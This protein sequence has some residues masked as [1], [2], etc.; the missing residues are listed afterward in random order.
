MAQDELVPSYFLSKTC[1]LENYPYFCAPK[2]IIVSNDIQRNESLKTLFSWY[3]QVTMFLK[4]SLLSCNTLCTK[5]MG[6]V[7]CLQE[8]SFDPNRMFQCC[9]NSFGICNN[10]LLGSLFL[11]TICSIHCNENFISFF[12]V[13]LFFCHPDGYTH[14]F[15]DDNWTFET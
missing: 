8:P 2:Y 5:R 15:Y 13:P 14:E 1:K 10:K 4:T 12:L 9:F 11:Q 3:F 7:S 6:I